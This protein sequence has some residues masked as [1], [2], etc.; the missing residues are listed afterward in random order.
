MS[1]VTLYQFQ[2]EALKDTAS[3]NRVAY[4]HE[5]GLGKTFT[6]SEKL[7]K[8]SRPL[9]L[10]ICQKSKIDDWIKHFKEHYPIVRVYNLTKSKEFELF[11]KDA[12][13]DGVMKLGIINY[14]LVWRRP[15]LLTLEDFTLMLD[16]SSLIQNSKAKQTKFILNLSFKNVILLSGTPCSGKYE[17]LWTQ[18]HLLGWGISEELFLS[19]FVNYKLIRI[20]KAFHKTVDTANPYRNVE[21][22]KSKMR[23]YGCNFLR[24]EEC[25]DLPEQTFINV[26][27]PVSDVY[28]FFMRNS[29]ININGVEL[30]GSTTLTK[31]LYAR[32]LCGVYS[33][34]KLEAFKDLLEST[35]DRLIVFYNFTEELRRLEEVVKDLGKPMSIV[36]GSIKDLKAYESYSDSVTLVQYQ[37]GAKG[38]NLQKANK[39]IF[40]SPT[41]RCE[42]YM[43]ALKRIHR[44]GQN[45]PCFYYRMSCEN[46][47]EEKIYNAL[48]RGEDYTNDLFKEDYR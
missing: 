2:Q 11:I 25:F 6:G 15:N 37:A 18:L 28:K 4:Y 16:E 13:Y 40:Y 14:E 23:E 30:V 8:L 31:R 47:V 17:N 20:G 10:L 5:M 27:V 48:E 43:Q 46:S 7:Y 1:N 35:N 42:D 45:K 22:L 26:K 29:I 12:S 41:E 44:I 9:N 33:K 3:R 34:A 19:Q 39:I 36:N 38:L 24:T 21:R 32:M